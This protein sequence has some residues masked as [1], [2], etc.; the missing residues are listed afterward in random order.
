MTLAKRHYQRL[1]FPKPGEGGAI[2]SRAEHGMSRAEFEA[3]V[4]E[5]FWRQVVDRVNREA[6]NTLLLAEAFWLMEG[7]FVRTLG[8]HRVYNS[9]FMN[10]LKM[11]DNAQYRT[12]VKNVLEFSPEVLKRF[13][14]F[15]NNPDELTAVEQFGKGDKYFGIVVLMV[16]MPGLPMFGHGQIEGYAEKY[17]MEYRRAY[18]DEHADEDLVRRHEAEIFPLMHKRY[19]F[20]GVEH[21]AFYDFYTP[22]GYV[23]ENVFVLSNR[24]GAERALIVYNNAYGCTSGWVC[25]STAINVGTPEEGPFVHKTLV[26]ALDLK[27]ED[28]YYYVFRD[29]KDGLEYLRQGRDLGERGLFVELQGYQHQAFLDFREVRDSDGSWARLAGRLGGRGVLDM[30]EAHCEMLLLPVLDAFRA[31]MNAELIQLVT[32]GVYDGA[33]SEG[34]S[35]A[36]VHIRQGSRAFLTALADR[37][38]TPFNSEEIIGEIVAGTEALRRFKTLVATAPLEPGL[39]EYLRSRLPHP[40]GEEVGEAASDPAVF[41]RIPFAWALIRPLGK[42]RALEDYEA[43]SVQ[44]MDEWMLTKVVVEAFSDLGCESF[45]AVHDAQLLKILIRFWPLVTLDTSERRADE[46]RRM[47]ED[48]NVREYLLIHRYGGVLWLNRERMETLIYWMLFLSGVVRS[49]DATL[50]VAAMCATLLGSFTHA[51]EI[52]AAVELAGYQVEKVPELLQ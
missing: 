25:R 45:P 8:M 43:Q 50:S 16:T 41:W 21:F 12:T 51:Q 9:A 27:T 36:C 15:M 47:F 34:A 39:A 7:Y 11:E 20:S 40:P 38:S 22:Q 28:S 44:C 23:N 19:L 32:Q 48:A 30:A 24:A 31:V 14:N 10:M 37:V 33:V 5:E 49:F 4:P 29:N 42:V 2:P 3:A 35:P 26:E 13:V 1:W 52:L 46:L 6:P 17:G 18:W